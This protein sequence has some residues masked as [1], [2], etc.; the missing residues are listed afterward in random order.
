MT[1]NL[2]E[3]GGVNKSISD[4]LIEQ[5]IVPLMLML[6]NLLNDS[7]N[8]GNQVRRSRRH[9]DYNGHV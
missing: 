2:I 7:L 8:I 4:F 3:N 5:I 1:I 9:F 6:M